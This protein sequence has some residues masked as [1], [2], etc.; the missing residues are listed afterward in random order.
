MD[1]TQDGGWA[2]IKLNVEIAAENCPLGSLNTGI[3][4]VKVPKIFL[5]IGILNA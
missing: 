5:E 4:A 3:P 1:I 2:T